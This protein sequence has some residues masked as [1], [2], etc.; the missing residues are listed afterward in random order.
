MERRQLVDLIDKLAA[1]APVSTAPPPSSS[2]S[3]H[4]KMT[5]QASGTDIDL[6]TSTAMPAATHVFS[7]STLVFGRGTG[8]GKAPDSTGESSET[9]DQFGDLNKASDAEVAAAKAKMDVEFN[10]KQLKPGDDGFEWDVRMD[11]EAGGESN[12]W[13]EESD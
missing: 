11:F 2:S 7:S 8:A 4:T 13:D 6:P 10:K 12:D 1:G 3:S 5:E 9:D